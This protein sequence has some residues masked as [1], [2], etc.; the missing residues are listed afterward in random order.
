M[1][2]AADFIWKKSLSWQLLSFELFIFH[3][4]FF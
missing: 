1:A 3:I 2:F 4:I